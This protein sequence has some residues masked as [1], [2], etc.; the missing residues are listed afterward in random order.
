MVD[1]GPSCAEN[2]GYGVDV[3][4]PRSTS[5]GSSTAASGDV[6]R[7][8][9][10]SAIGRLVYAF[11]AD[12]IHALAGDP[13]AALRLGCREVLASGGQPV[14]VV[15]LLLEAAATAACGAS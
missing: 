9:C 14:E 10:R 6:A 4:A 13:P 1:I 11:G 5:N 3:C 15:G 8:L 12:A 2:S 7:T